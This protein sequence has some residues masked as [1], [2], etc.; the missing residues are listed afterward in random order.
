MPKMFKIAKTISY[1]MGVLFITLGMIPVPVL[2]QIASAQIAIPAEAVNLE[3]VWPEKSL[4]MT[5]RSAVLVETVKPGINWLSESPLLNYREEHIE[6]I[7][8]NPFPYQSWIQ[9]PGLN[10]YCGDG[11]KNQAEECDG[12]D[13]PAGSPPGTT[14]NSDCT[15]NCPPHYNRSGGICVYVP[16]CGDGNRDAGEACD[17]PNGTTCDTSCQTIPIVCGNGILQS[18]EECDD[19]N[20]ENKDGCSQNCQIEQCKH[21]NAECTINASGHDCCP[22]LNCIPFN[23]NS[24]NGKCLM[25]GSSI[26][27]NGIKEGGETR[28]DGNTNNGDGCSS[29][30]QLEPPPQTC[31]NGVKEGTEE[32]DDGNT[33]DYDSC[34]SSCMIETPSCGNNHVES[35][36]GEQ[37]DP[38]NGT[39]C[40]TSCQTIPTVCGNGILQ[41][42]EACDDGNTT[43]YDGCS[44][45]C[46]IETPSCGNEHVESYV[47][48]QCDPPDGVLCDEKCKEIPIVCGNGIKQPGEACDDG[49]GIDDDACT[50]KCALPTCGDGIKQANEACDDQNLDNTDGCLQTCVLASCG[51]SFVW[52]GQEE[53]D[54][55][56]SD[57]TDGCIAC[58]LAVCGDGFLQA[59][60]EDCDDSNN[61]IGDGC[62][63][64]LLEGCTDPTAENYDPNASPGN[65]YAMEC[66]I[67]KNYMLYFDPY[68]SKIGGVWKLVWEVN[69]PNAF[70]VAV[71]CLLDGANCG[72]SL[73][74]GV[75][76]VGTTD[77]GP[78]NH[79][80]NVTWSTGS[81]SLSS[82]LVCETTTTTTPPVRRVVPPTIPVTGEEPLIIPVTGVDLAET[83]HQIAL[84]LGL[85][86]S[87]LGVG[88]EGISRRKR[89]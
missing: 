82:S 49:N 6:K 3:M 84:N 69:N 18:G 12:M 48:E 40:D 28:D 25:P 35:Y 11:V 57:E 54:D 81:G 61:V 24:G 8:L 2:S 30:C 66:E 16:Y 64:C 36:A 37:C 45:S 73:A 56:N 21:E 62:S 83:L 76:G 7:V 41:P 39:T 58:K 44:S 10:C 43:D 55:Q 72:S 46:T 13:I 9:K 86:L 14:C 87:G 17:P 60:V 50:N 27:G 77:P 20:T 88:L 32:C 67:A 85:A 80:L 1:V 68:C 71:T 89:K 22:P 47:G 70:A 79:T 74:P 65:E 23:P 33:T 5:A 78:A 42:G 63:R 19:G 52:A 31:G 51:D 29:T 59:G 4:L 53:C 38:P 15:L 34:S 75:N 26:C